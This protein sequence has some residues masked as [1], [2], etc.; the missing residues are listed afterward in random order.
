MVAGP[1]L[2]GVSTRECTVAGRRRPAARAALHA[3]TSSRPGELGRAGRLLPRRRLRGRRPGHPRAAVPAAR[4]ELGRARAQ[5][6]L[7]PR[8]GAPLPRR[9]RGRPRRLPQRGGPR[10]GVR[11]PGGAHRRRGRQRGRQPRRGHLAAGRR[12]RRAR[13]PRSS[14]S[15]TP[16]PT[17]GA[18]PPPG[19]SSPTASCS[20]RRTWT[21]MRSSTWA[22]TGT[23]RIPA[24]L[25]CWRRTSAASAPGARRDRRL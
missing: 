8:T 3:A 17:S 18:S 16:S 25:P 14:S 13:R 2:G 22:R 20:R 19:S 5:H 21:G 4:P 23:A 15:S 10:R 11:R 9:G 24:P 12:R 7:P 6:R 1:A